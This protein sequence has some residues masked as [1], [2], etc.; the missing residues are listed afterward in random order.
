AN[1]TAYQQKLRTEDEAVDASITRMGARQ[2]G[3]STRYS[4]Y[5]FNQTIRGL[6]GRSVWEFD[7]AFKQTVVA[8]A[9]YKHTET[10]RSHDRRAADNLTGAMS[11]S[12]AGSTSPHNPFYAKKHTTFSVYAQKNITFCNST[13][14]PPA[15]SYEQE[16]PNR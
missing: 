15:L 8:G 4:D 13:V 5:V 9:E 14:L 2:L 3:N 12:H 6:N 1:L 11:K 10:A 16:K 7:G